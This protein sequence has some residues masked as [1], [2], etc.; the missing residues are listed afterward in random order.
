MY[1]I[2]FSKQA[3]KDIQSLNVK[4]KIKLKN[5]F[6]NIIMINPNEWKKLIWDLKWYMSF[7]LNFKDRIVYRINEQEKCVYVLMCRSHYGE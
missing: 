6:E 2:I 4:Q 3:K 5:L 7:R 1:K